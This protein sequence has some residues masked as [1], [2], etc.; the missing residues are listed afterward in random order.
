MARLDSTKRA[1][2]P[3]SAFAYVDSR[4]RRRLPIHDEAHVRNA[5]ARFNQVDFEDERGPRAGPQAAAEGGQE[6]RDRAGR[7]H[8]RSAAIRAG[9]RSRS[10]PEPV[11]LPSGFVTMLMTDIEGSTALVDRLGDRYGE[12]LDAVRA[13]LEDAA[14]RCDGHVVETRA[15]EFF[16]VFER[17]GS[18]RRHGGG[19]PAGAPGTV[20]GGGSRSAGTSRHS[21][22]LPDAHRGELHRHGRSHRGARVCGGTRRADP[23]LRRHQ[24]GGRGSTPTACGSGVSVRSGSAACPTRYAVPGRGERIGHPLPAAADIHHRLKR[25]AQST[26]ELL[27]VL[28]SGWSPPRPC[29]GER[30]SVLADRCWYLTSR[31]SWSGRRRG[32][33]EGVR[34]AARP[35]VLMAREVRVGRDRSPRAHADRDARMTDAEAAARRFEH[36]TVLANI[37]AGHVEEDDA[38]EVEVDG[39]DTRGDQTSESTGER[40]RRNR[41]DR[42]AHVRFALRSRSVYSAPAGP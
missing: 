3:D 22:R 41:V 32:G 24:E 5:L 18:A 7:F 29:S 26:A 15:D 27:R 10:G 8:H 21:Q 39:R 19:R 38:L 12:L 37:R 14:R 6:V 25:D 34:Q 16:A 1:K 23:R 20:V 36:A 35:R 17:P 4:G 28:S 11:Q 13:I 42:T 33:G 2:L 40:A 30:R 31:S 9:A